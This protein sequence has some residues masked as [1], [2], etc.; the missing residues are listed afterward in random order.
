MKNSIK[1]HCF[2]SVAALF[3]LVSF[4]AVT[5]ETQWQRIPLT[6][7]VNQVAEEARLV[8]AVDLAAPYDANTAYTVGSVA[9]QTG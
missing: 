4:A 2:S 9:T 8:R 6:N 5:P 3:A 7:T 1:Q